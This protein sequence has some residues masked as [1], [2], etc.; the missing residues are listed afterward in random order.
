M[1]ALLL[2]SLIL[3]LVAFGLG[4]LI[5]WLIKKTFCQFRYAHAGGSSGSA[6]SFRARSNRTLVGG[7]TGSLAGGAALGSATVAGAALAKDGY[8]SGDADRDLAEDDRVEA[9]VQDASDAEADVIAAIE[10]DA[11]AANEPPST[12]GK[13]SASDDERGREI[14]IDVVSTERPVDASAGVSEDQ[15]EAAPAPAA[16]PASS[17]IS[18]DS[19]A[20]SDV[21]HAAETSESQ[22]DPRDEDLVAALQ[23]ELNGG[24]DEPGVTPLGVQTAVPPAKLVSSI[25]STVGTDKA[26][27]QSGSGDM[28]QLS[29]T[30]LEDAEVAASQSQV[31]GGLEGAIAREAGEPGIL[32]FTT[33]D[34]Q[35]I[36]GIG[37]KMESLLNENGIFTWAQLAAETDDSLK[38]KF[39]PYEGQYQI[40]QLSDWIPQAQ[41]AAQGKA[42]DL[43]ALQ[44]KDGASKI[45][46]LLAKR[47]ISGQKPSTL[48]TGDSSKGA[49]AGFLGIESDN[50]EIIEGIG[51]KMQSI[52]HENGVATWADLAGHSEPALKEMLGRYGGRYQIIDPSDWIAQAKLAA[53]GQ[54]EELI[55]LQKRDGVSKLERMLDSGVNSG[56]GRY[57]KDDLKI[58][59]GI[60]PKIQE[61][62]KE[63][64]IETWK[65]LS[66]TDSA[67]IRSILHAA[68]P[69]YR[70]ADPATWPKQAE[71]AYLGDWEAL[72]RYQA[73]LKGGRK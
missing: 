35:I 1:I 42:D 7:E 46:R 27:S 70:L 11:V 20:D 64:G 36:E 5:G 18:A 17:T 55:A 3:L 65:A 73:T 60:G 22:L 57:K 68:G 43:I 41:L 53:A 10:V 37:P 58:V 8:R 50:L 31:V 29:L 13:F 4:L 38:Q 56:F 32:G 54:P 49:S 39:A 61:L 28:E 67:Q 25:A 40:N 14:D 51:P 71:Y 62:L 6:S 9:L 48:A 72:K 47:S 12:A 44:K 52:L 21:P 59:E 2:Q 69:R 23:A 30:D 45:E 66:E 16:E 24:G 34:L 15:T 63:G 19:A 33:D 26:D